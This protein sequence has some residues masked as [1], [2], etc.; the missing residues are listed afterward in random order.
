MGLRREERKVT[1][2]YLALILAFYTVA[3][4]GLAY[5]VG[6]SRVSTGIREWLVSRLPN[7][8]ELLQCPMCFGFWTGVIVG[9]FLDLGFEQRLEFMFAL[10][11]YTS[12]SNF[13]ISRLTDLIPPPPHD[14]EDEDDDA[15]PERDAEDSAH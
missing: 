5:I 4:F 8:V 12:G 7:V 2:G 1:A 6:H 14:D 13:L 15:E 9:C 3:A 11:L 10:G